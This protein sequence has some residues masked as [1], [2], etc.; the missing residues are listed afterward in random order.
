M[1]NES[2]EGAN[3]STPIDPEAKYLTGHLYSFDEKNVEVIQGK[4][5]FKVP[6]K[7]VLTNHKNVVGSSVVIKLASSQE[8]I[9]SRKKRP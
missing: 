7:L 8:I 3:L 4:I 2:H 1:D 5:I 9:S 6:H